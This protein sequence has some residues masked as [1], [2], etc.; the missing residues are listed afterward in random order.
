M[1]TGKNVG[2]TEALLPVRVIFPQ[3]VFRTAKSDRPT[4][5]L[6]PVRTPARLHCCTTSAEGK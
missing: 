1:P 6:L 5:A 4:L 2:N 3:R